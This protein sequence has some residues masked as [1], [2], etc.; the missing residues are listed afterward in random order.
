MLIHLHDY[1]LL[2]IAS[3]IVIM[4]DYVSAQYFM[5]IAPK[6]STIIVCITKSVDSSRTNTLNFKVIYKVCCSISSRL[7]NQAP[8][9]ESVMLTKLYVC[10]IVTPS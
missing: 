7:L 6:F 4:V 10:G 5:P 2:L 3:F 1:L 8:T 9:A